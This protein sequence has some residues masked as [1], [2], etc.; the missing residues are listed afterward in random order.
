[1]KEHRMSNSKRGAGRR[2]RLLLVPVV[3]AGT[4]SAGF[5]ALSASPAFATTT[6]GNSCTLYSNVGLFGGAAATLGCGTQTSSYAT[7]NSAAP[8]TTW[9]G[10]ATNV[11]DSDGAK[12]T[13]GPADMVSSPWLTGDTTSNTGV[14]TAQ[15]SG[16]SSVAMVSKVVGIGPSP[17]YTSTPVSVD[18]PSTPS[19]YI[20]GSCSAS[21]PSTY[22][23]QT[24]VSKGY[25]DTALDSNGYPTATTAVTNPATNTSISYTIDNLVTGG[26]KEHGHIVFNQR[27]VNADGSYTVNGAHM[28][29]EGPIALGDVF[30][31]QVTCSHA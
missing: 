20:Q 21:G 10:T 1:M 23:G 2:A 29:L 14:L 19:G 18:N 24:T 6:Y 26:V 27:V 8:S 30:Y 17:L 3:A 12:L 22:S 28:Y 25:V 11:V 16:T 4:I 5:L 31:A 15:S 7:S 13:Y 9:T